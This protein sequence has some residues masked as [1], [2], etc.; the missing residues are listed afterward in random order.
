MGASDV[1]RRSDAHAA[2]RRALLRRRS[3]PVDLWNSAT[4][5]ISEALIPYLPIVMSG[6]DAWDTDLTIERAIEIRDGAVQN[7]KILSFQARS[8]MFPYPKQRT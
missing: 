1:V 3:Q 5:K 2:R 4:W 8:P 6:Q 7:P